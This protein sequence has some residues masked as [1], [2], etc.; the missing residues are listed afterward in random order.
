M[1]YRTKYSSKPRIHG[2]NMVDWAFVK[3]NI[4]LLG[5]TISS[6]T[7]EKNIFL[8]LQA[9][10][11]MWVLKRTVSVRRFFEYPHHM[12]SLRNKKILQPFY[13]QNLGSTG[14]FLLKLTFFVFVLREV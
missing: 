11:M 6:R 13:T 3:A 8:I 1:P 12:F 14:A 7:P 2:I 10:I 5:S 4:C 9:N